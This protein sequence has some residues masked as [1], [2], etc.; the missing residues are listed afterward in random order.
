MRYIYKVGA[1]I[2]KKFMEHQVFAEDVE[3]AIEKVKRA[4]L[5]TAREQ[6]TGSPSVVVLEVVSVK[7]G[8]VTIE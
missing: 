8:Y 1:T 7:D 3:D 2:N 5:K 6:A 4:V